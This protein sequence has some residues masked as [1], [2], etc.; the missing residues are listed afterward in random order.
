[1]PAGGAISAFVEYFSGMAKGWGIE[2]NECAIAVTKVILDELTVV[3]MADTGVGICW[4]VSLQ[5]LTVT[6][7]SA[8]MP[9]ACFG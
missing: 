9:Q 1:M 5:L 8:A 6:A 4:A 2:M 7:D 3:A